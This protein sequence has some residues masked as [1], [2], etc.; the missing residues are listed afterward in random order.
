MRVEYPLELID[1][2]TFEQMGV[3]LA[4]AVIGNG[5]EIFGD[6]GQASCWPKP[7]LIRPL[8]RQGRP[9]S[10]GGRLPGST[11]APA[12]LRGFAARRSCRE[13]GVGESSNLSGDADTRIR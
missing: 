4:R 13:S 5:V 7:D 3:A 2:K 9:D 10:R 8:P 12:R 6:H 1:P 11:S